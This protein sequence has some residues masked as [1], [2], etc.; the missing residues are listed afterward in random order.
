MSGPAAG[1]R[2]VGLLVAVL[3]SAVAGLAVFIL[4]TRLGSR[5]TEA[6]LWAGSAFGGSMAVALGA[7]A[8][9][10]GG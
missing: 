7:L 5:A 1:A 6:A 8:F 2:L 10:F 9:A 3:V 4:R